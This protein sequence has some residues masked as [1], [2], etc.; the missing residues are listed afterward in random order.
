M[1]TVVKQPFREA[2]TYEVRPVLNFY[3]RWKSPASRGLKLGLRLSGKLVDE[4]GDQEFKL[5]LDRLKFVIEPANNSN[6]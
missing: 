3:L 4:K 2:M 5:G 6:H 1:I